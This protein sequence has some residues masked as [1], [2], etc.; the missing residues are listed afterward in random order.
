MPKSENYYTMT[1]AVH[2][3]WCIKSHMQQFASKREFTTSHCCN[4]IGSNMLVFTVVDRMTS[5][6]PHEF[7]GFSGATIFRFVS[8]SPCAILL[9]ANVIP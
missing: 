4:F 2:F 3:D 1:Q 8:V 9:A 7:M 5:L 6:S